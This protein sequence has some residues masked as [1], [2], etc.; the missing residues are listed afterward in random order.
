MIR[1]NQILRLLK[2]LNSKLEKLEIQGELY[3]LG[4]A[5]MCLAFDTRASTNDIDAIFAPRTKI[6]ELALEIAEEEKLES[7]WLNDAVKGYLSEEGTFNPYL[8]LSNLKI[9]IASPEYLLAMKCL[10]MR[11]GKEFHDEA[12]VR[13]LLRYLN[14]ERYEKAIEVISRYY[15]S[16][17]FPQ[18]TLYALEEI[19]SG[20]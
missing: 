14:I 20:G 17:K 16:D 11:I 12:D 7:D 5:V 1:K 15:P 8:E 18:K 2:V 3:L 13:Y 10:A 4:G 9:L 19:L 6:R